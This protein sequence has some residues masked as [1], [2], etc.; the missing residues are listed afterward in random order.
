MT[1]KTKHFMLQ[2]LLPK[3]VFDARGGKG[4]ELLDDRLLISVDSIRERYG[5]TIINNWHNGGDRQWSGLRTPDS[6]YYSP[7]SQHTFG[8]AADCIVLNESAESIRQDILSNPELFP[9][10]NGIEMGVSWLHIDVRNTDRIK[11]F[12]P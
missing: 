9:Y 1:Y 11:R 5:A 8:R 7:Y 2:E 12:Y 6:P 3:R 4:W 10:V